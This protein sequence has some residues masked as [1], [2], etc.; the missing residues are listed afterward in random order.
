MADASPVPLLV[1]NFPLAAGGIDLL[2]GCHRRAGAAP[3]IAGCKLTCGNTGKAETGIAAAT[4]AATAADPGS[5]FMCLGGSADFLLQTLV[6]G[7][8]GTIAGF[9]NVAPKA[10]VELARL[11]DAGEMTAARKLQAVVARGDWAAIRGGIV[12]TKSAMMSH[13]GYGGY[14][15]KPL[16]RPNKE[17]AARW[18]EAFE[19]SVA[20]ERSL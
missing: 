13:F 17:E 9:A 7:G 3:N 8:S 10:C 18:R 1:Y 5:G 20:L 14:A 12:G 2:V 19:E 15:R 11:A 16:P 6:G 4:R